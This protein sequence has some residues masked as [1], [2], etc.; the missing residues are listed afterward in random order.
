LEPY[1]FSKGQSAKVKE[2]KPDNLTKGNILKLNLTLASPKG[3]EPAVAQTRI[4]QL[5]SQKEKPAMPEAT[6][7]LVVIA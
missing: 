5:L 4:M 3:E 7:T 1:S 2:K 6:Q